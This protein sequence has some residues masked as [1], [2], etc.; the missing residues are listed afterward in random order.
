MFPKREDGFCRCGC[1][2]RPTKGKLG[3]RGG[4]AS[5]G[6]TED[7][8]IRFGSASHIR[9][10]LFRRDRG[11]CAD[12]GMDTEAEREACCYWPRLDY[13]N[14]TFRPNPEQEAKVEA[15]N[16]KR[17]EML[18]RGFPSPTRTWWEAAHVV[19]VIEGGGARGLD[20]FKTLC[21]ACHKRDTKALA[22]RRARGR[23][24]D[25]TNELFVGC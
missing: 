24:G 25:R 13:R 2:E 9:A 11:I 15:G 20:N 7:A 4:W 1:G 16:A 21:C 18:R 6:C 10:A 5:P 19:A 22:N 17:L 3:F 12:C 8:L 23:R 14:R